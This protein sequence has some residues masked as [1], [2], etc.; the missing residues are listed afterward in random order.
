MENI[1]GGKEIVDGIPIRFQ[2]TAGDGGE[3]EIIFLD[4]KLV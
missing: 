1:F 2:I 4:C 3:T